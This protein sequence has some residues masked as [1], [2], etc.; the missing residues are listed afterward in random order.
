VRGPSGSGKELVAS[1]LH[2]RSGRRGALVSRNATTLPPGLVDAELF[3]NVRGY[4]NPGMPAR[5]GLVGAARDGTLFLD[6]V[7]DVPEEVQPHLL[8][9][10]DGGEYHSLG[11]HRSQAANLRVVAATHRPTATLRH[12]LL[13]RFPLR[14]ELSGL[15][16][17]RADLPLLA[18][19]LLRRIAAREP[20]LG[21]RFLD[22]AGHPRLS[23]ALVRQLLLHPWTTHARELEA[24]L[25]SAMLASRGDELEPPPRVPAGAA[26]WTEPAEPTDWRQ[27][28]GSRPEDLPAAALI[29]AL[30]AH[31][32]HQ[33]RTAAALGLS[34]RYVLIR[35]LR[36]HG[37]PVVRRA[38]G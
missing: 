7:G 34:S 15:T 36:R 6:E 4:P 29:A 20:D 24:L 8:R 9:L 18:A 16:E 23:A 35:L 3:G 17:R 33:E 21:V 5:P 26:P 13:A 27:W 38:G 10:L 14:I 1:G 30:D 31:D 12:D 22:P 37:I 25:W 32:A 19:H 2:R 11:D 28:I